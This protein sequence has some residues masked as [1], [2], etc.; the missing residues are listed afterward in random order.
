MRL[1]ST[2]LILPFLLSFATAAANLRGVDNKVQSSDLPVCPTGF[3]KYGAGPCYF[4]WG[5]YHQCFA[6]VDGSCQGPGIKSCH[7][8]PR[9]DDVATDLCRYPTLGPCIS[10]TG[11]CYAYNS[12][13]CC[14]PETHCIADN[15]PPASTC[16]NNLVASAGDCCESGAGVCE[17]LHDGTCVEMDA[18]RM[19]PNGSKSCQS[20]DSQHRNVANIKSVLDAAQCPVTLRSGDQV[21]ST[22]SV[23]LRRTSGT[24]EVWYELH[25]ATSEFAIKYEGDVIWSVSGLVS[26]NGNA[27]I[28]LP[29]EG[30]SSMIEAQINVSP[31]ESP[32]EVTIGCSRCDPSMEECQNQLCSAYPILDE[33]FIKLAQNAAL[34]SDAVYGSNFTAFPNAYVVKDE[35]EQAMFYREGNNCFLAFRGSIP[36]PRD[37]M[38]NLNT[39]VVNACSPFDTCC[40]TRK[41]FHEA[42]VKPNFRSDLEAKIRDCVHAEDCPRD[43]C[44]AILTGHSQ[45]G[46][47]AIIAAIYLEDLNPVVI[48][49]AA[50]PTVG[51]CSAIHSNCIYQF[52][53]TRVRN[54]FRVYDPVAFLDVCEI[55]D[56]TP[57]SM[58][59]STPVSNRVSNLCSTTDNLLINGTGHMFLLSEDPDNVVWYKNGAVPDYQGMEYDYTFIPHLTGGESGYVSRLEALQARPYVGI[60][61]WKDG[62]LCTHNTECKNGNCSFTDIQ[63]HFGRKQGRCL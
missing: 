25:N 60:D 22:F 27:I 53:N 41:G 52:S 62:S 45:G 58:R 15:C 17:L 51:P 36:T 12:L 16:W 33:S 50:A 35:P 43:G 23:D 48:T 40:K 32:W 11:V 10:V 42:Y 34:M 39:G 28:S 13:G 55:P 57:F 31:P 30:S 2:E 26:G 47:I 59:I 54:G 18:S 3:C 7:H 20:V 38:H 5:D 49:F 1:H 21:T 29:L 4:D 19:C 61:G 24:F 56:L 37:W 9:E 6:A 44:N 8:H 63:G 46:S 14:P